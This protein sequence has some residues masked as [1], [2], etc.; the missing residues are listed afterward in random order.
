MVAFFSGCIPAA[1]YRLLI[2]TILERM[3]AVAK[4]SNFVWRM[5]ENS[6][7]GS[8]HA[9]SLIKALSHAATTCLWNLSAPSQQVTGCKLIMHVGVRLCT[10][11]RPNILVSD[12]GLCH[13]YLQTSGRSDSQCMPE[14]WGSSNGAR[15]NEMLIWRKTVFSRGNFRQTHAY[16]LIRYI[17]LF[18]FNFRVR[19][20]F[21]VACFNLAT[22]SPNLYSQTKCRHNSGYSRLLH[23]TS[24]QSQWDD[25]YWTNRPK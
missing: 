1:G 8:M 11:I 6:S 25:W 12:Y 21:E 13:C 9:W 2:L 23:L 3:I 14:Q 20:E 18:K 10:W 17:N 22:S 7:L 15:Y 16:A 19:C 4:G 5:T 24:S